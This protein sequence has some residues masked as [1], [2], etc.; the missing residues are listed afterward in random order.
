MEGG[1][2]PGTAGGGGAAG[3]GGGRVAGHVGEEEGEDLRGGGEA[4]EAAAFEDRDV[5]SDGV[6]LPDIRP[7]PEEVLRELFEVPDLDGRRRVG[8][9]GRRPTRDEGQE[10]I[11]LLQRLRQLP[12]RSE[13][14]R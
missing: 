4:G 9:Q 6:D 8:E 2:A 13:E 14:R 12:H 3:D 11:P 7:A 1:A 10:Q 5:F